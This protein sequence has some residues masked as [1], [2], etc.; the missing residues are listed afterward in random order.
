MRAL[1]EAETG[2]PA[3]GVVAGLAGV[4][5][6]GAS[7]QAPATKSVAMS[8]KKDWREIGRISAKLRQTD[9]NGRG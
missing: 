8:A 1:P 5:V 3:A 4:L 7:L 6:W 9:Q 2:E